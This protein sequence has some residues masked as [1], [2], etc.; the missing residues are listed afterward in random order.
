MYS[1]R[2]TRQSCREELEY[3]ETGRGVT[4]S[5][6]L[7]P[8]KRVT[9]SA[10]EATVKS[11]CTSTFFLSRPCLTR[12]KPDM[13]GLGRGTDRKNLSGQLDTS[14]TKCVNNGRVLFGHTPQSD[15][16]NL[17]LPPDNAQFYRD[18][19]FK[20]TFQ[21][22]PKVSG[23]LEKSQL[24]Q[25]INRQN[26]FLCVAVQHRT[27][28][29]QLAFKPSRKAGNNSDFWFWQ[30]KL[31]RSGSV[32]KSSWKAQQI[33][34]QVQMRDSDWQWKSCSRSSPLPSL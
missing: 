4:F 7:L 29:H 30:N 10:G 24:C 25:N 14:K 27:M 23:Y 3:A 31:Q 12:C 34:L 16:Q 13:L 18:N 22:F 11:R 5:I 6:T 33:Y 17:S 26:Y 32:R 21:S 8:P 15:K 19:S 28:L 2:E 1:L 20:T 9:N